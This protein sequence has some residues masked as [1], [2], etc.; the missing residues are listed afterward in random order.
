MSRLSIVTRNKAQSTVEELYKDL[1]RR[2]VASPPGLCPVDLA[3][4]FLNMCHCQT[5]GKCVPCRIGLG[6]LQ[7]LLDDVLNGDANMDTLTLI[8]ET[9]KTIYYSADCAIG[10]EAAHMVLTGLEGFRDDYIEHIERGKCISTLDQPVPCSALC[11]AGV[12]IPGYIALVAEGRY[13]DAVRLIRKD[14]PLVAVCGLI[15]EHPCEARCRRNMVDDAVNIRG[16]K[17]FAVDNA[18]KVPAPTPAE[19][20]GKSVAVIGGGAGGISAAYF[21]SLMGHKVTIFEQRKRLG[22]MLAYGIPNYRLPKDLLDAEIEILLSNGVEVKTEVSVGKD[23]SMKQLE[24]DF[25]AVYIAIGAH[26]DKKIGIEGE[27]GGRVLSA[28]TM[29]REIGDG[30]R[31][32][33][34]GKRV[35]VI[36]GG[37]VAMDVARSA[38][39]CGAED[40]LIV[41]RRR[42]ADMTALPEEVEGAIAEGCE[43]KELMAPVRIEL[44]EEGNACALWVQPQIIGEVKRGRPAPS[45]ADTEEVRIPVDYVLVSIGQGIE[46]K[47]FEDAGIPVQRGVISALSDSG[48]QDI[49]GVF[50]GGDCV[51]GPATVIRAIAAGKVGAANIDEYL[52]FEHEISVDVDIPAPRFAD[53][54]ACGRVT[55]KERDAAERKND[56]ELAECG[57]SYEEAMQESR[58]CLRCD[59]FG[60]GGFKGGRVDKW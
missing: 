7:N 16:L 51:T 22:G 37:N 53:K 31:P 1:E 59:H 11:P 20:T 26:T 48:F 34:T 39:R 45:N 54:P 25:D 8:E 2:I 56:F 46:V 24:D 36:G 14:N 21:L 41:Y 9:A 15:C 50:A 49:P 28:V 58:R 6:Q 60:Y 57:M 35:A 38:V 44:D 47:Q 13:A 42:I 4:S 32:D 33:F 17:R 18:G 19:P 27:E 55:M 23:I 30:I 43:V 40:T 3:K 10:Y 29:L 52:G 5:C 12:D